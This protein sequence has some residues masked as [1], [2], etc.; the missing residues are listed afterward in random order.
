M[1]VHVLPNVADEFAVCVPL[2]KSRKVTF[3]VVKGVLDWRIETDG[4]KN[5]GFFS[6]NSFRKSI[7]SLDVDSLKVE[8]GD[9]SAPENLKKLFSIIDYSR[10]Y[11]K[12]SAI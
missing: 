1:T 6:E 5:D 4:K 3:E 2:S 11:N 9:L 7:S 12:N 8:K 10:S